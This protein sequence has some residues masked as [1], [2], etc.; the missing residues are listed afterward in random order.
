MNR[1]AGLYATLDRTR[2]TN[3]KIEAVADYLGEVES[4]DVGPGD[5][6]W[7]LFLLIGRRFE[8]LVGAGE[9]EHLLAEYTGMPEWLVAECLDDVGDLAETIALLVDGEGVTVAEWQHDPRPRPGQADLEGMGLRDWVEQEVQPLAELSKSAR[10]ER[11]HGWWR[12]LDPE[13]IFVTGKMLTGSLRVGVSGSLV[14]KAL[15][16]VAPVPAETIQSRLTRDW[17][18]SP[19][20]YSD[21]VEPDGHLREER[22]DERGDAG[23]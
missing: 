17:A 13:T 8:R 20:A 1:F 14:A 15:A 7:A 18:P 23:A 6:A 16:R 3:A 12:T 19:A 5:A 10:A 9:L 11:L 4:G 22:P 21:L 2:S